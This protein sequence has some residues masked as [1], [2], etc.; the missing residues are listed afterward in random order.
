[1]IYLEPLQGDNTWE[2]MTAR[3]ILMMVLDVSAVHRSKL[4]SLDGVLSLHGFWVA[5]LIQYSIRAHVQCQRAARIRKTRNYKL[6][7]A[8]T[9]EVVV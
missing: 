2:A 7:V 3:G 5:P 9:Q 4:R 6:T 8:G 1:M